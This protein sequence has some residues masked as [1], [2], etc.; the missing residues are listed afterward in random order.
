MHISFS[1][2]T[3]TKNAAPR[4]ALSIHSVQEQS[5]ANYEH[6]IIDGLSCD[7]TLKEIKKLKHPKLQ[8]V[9][10][11]DNGIYDAMNKGAHLAKG[12][13]LLF[14]NA[15]DHLYDRNVLKNIFESLHS[16]III[17]K[18]DK[19]SS[20]KSGLPDLIVANIR[21]LD[22]LGNMDV[23]NKVGKPSKS[24]QLSEMANINNKTKLNKADRQ[25][26]QIWRPIQLTK[27]PHTFQVLP[28]CG[29]FIRRDFFIASGAYSLKYKIAADLEFFNRALQ[30]YKASYTY[31]DT[32]VSV[33]YRDGI[34][35]S[36]WGKALAYKE[37]L[38]IHWL[39]YGILNTLRRLLPIP[40]FG[41]W[42]R[43]SA[44]FGRSRL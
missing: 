17:K 22:T 15:G 36:C 13:Y 28:H 21:T 3:V 27:H 25:K 6:W 31:L 8:Y 23:L 2:I 20:I 33:F 5:F 39:Y 4:I 41:F 1:I 29:V 34:S 37:E 12:E 14:L 11:K 7:D 24:D 16:K 40:Y 35:S 19:R 44:I 30:K 38:Q 32:T 18:K 42:T 10:E 43:L 26:S 9:S